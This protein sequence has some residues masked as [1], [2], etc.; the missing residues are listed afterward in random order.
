MNYDDTD[1]LETV[2]C[3]FVGAVQDFIHRTDKIDLDEIIITFGSD[4]FTI[5]ADKPETKKGTPQDIN[6]YYDKIYAVGAKVAIDTISY[7][8]GK[9]R[10]IVVIGL[11]GNHDEQS[12]VW[13][14]ICLKH[15]FDSAADV[16]VDWTYG[17]RKY[18]RCSNNS[19]FK[20]KILN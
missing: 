2:S 7:L 20:L 6:A 16:V 1:T 4:Y 18:Y 17:H 11:P 3:R 15:Y 5:N 9:A 14:M 8:R 19:F 12:T 10:K 13:L